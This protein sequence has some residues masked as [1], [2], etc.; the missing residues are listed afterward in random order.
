V[1]ALPAAAKARCTGADGRPDAAFAKLYDA[2][3]ETE[4]AV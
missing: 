4:P 1:N 3:R 2:L